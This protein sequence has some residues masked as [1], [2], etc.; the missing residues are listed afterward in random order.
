[1]EGHR[2]D[3]PIRP[4][5]HYTSEEFPSIDIII[6]KIYPFIPQVAE[7]SAYVLSSYRDLGEILSSWNRFQGPLSQDLLHSWTLWYYQWKPYVMYEMQY[8]DLV[9]AKRKIIIQLYT[10]LVPSIQ[11]RQKGPQKT[12]GV[13]IDFVLE[14]LRTEVVPP[15]DKDY[16]PKTLLF[17]NHITLVR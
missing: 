1:M 11:A 14:R 6:N 17:K 9:H 15:T 3:F 16:D 5:K 4:N 12:Q 2:P 7:R 13:T 10:L 8:P